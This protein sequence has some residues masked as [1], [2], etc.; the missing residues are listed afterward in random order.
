MKLSLYC[1]LRPVKDMA[2]SF[3]NICSTALWCTLSLAVKRDVTDEVK[4]RFIQNN[5]DQI[6]RS[7]NSETSV[8]SCRSL[9]LI[10]CGAISVNVL[11]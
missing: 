5:I 10:D 6:A 4:K 3:S 11:S 2:G 1:G 9:S 7:V 8:F